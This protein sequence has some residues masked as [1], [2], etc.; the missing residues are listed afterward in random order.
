MKSGRRRPRESFAERRERHAAIDDPNVVLDA[1]MRFLEAR[2]RSIDEVRRRLRTAGYTSELIDGAIDRLTA[3]GI[4]DDAAFAKAWV[5]SRDRARPRG[6]RA[7]RRELQ[8]KGIDRSVVDNVLDERRPSGGDAE[9]A[10]PDATAAE[11]LLARHSAALARVVDPRQRR[12]RAYALLARN[13][14]DPE[15]A[16]RLS[17]SIVSD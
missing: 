1:A 15:V 12:Q 7:L 13:G 9:A 14:F 2:A 6:E 8:L 17:A 4:L 5:E 3:L 11:R 16:A 10:D